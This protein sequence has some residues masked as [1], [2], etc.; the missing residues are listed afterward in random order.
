MAGPGSLGQIHLEQFFSWR[1]PGWYLSVHKIGQNQLQQSR[2]CLAN[3]LGQ[4]HFQDLRDQKVSLHVPMLHPDF[5]K[6]DLP[7]WW[8][9]DSRHKCRLF[10]LFLESSFLHTA[11][12]STQTWWWQAWLAT[13]LPVENLSCLQRHLAEQADIGRDFLGSI[14]KAFYSP[15][16][17]KKQIKFTLKKQ[18]VSKNHERVKM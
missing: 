17:L 2:K 6:Q 14:P 4:K 11:V 13:L 3:L 10:Q 1:C 7:H 5:V 12:Y 8:K 9:E 18:R 15:K 16:T